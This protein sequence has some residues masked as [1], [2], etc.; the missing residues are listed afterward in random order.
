MESE[1]GMIVTTNRYIWFAPFVHKSFVSLRLEPGHRRRC[2]FDASLVSYSRIVV[3]S[4]DATFDGGT[5]LCLSPR[6]NRWSS[7]IHPRTSD[8]PRR[9]ALLLLWST[10]NVHARY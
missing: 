10:T 2:R 1:D 9:L 6:S 7:S 5:S 8:F 3:L 4:S